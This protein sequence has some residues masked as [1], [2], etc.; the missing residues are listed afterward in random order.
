MFYEA[1]KRLKA[2]PK[3][4]SWGIKDK[5]DN[6][7]MSKTEMLERWAEFYEDNCSDD[8]PDT[9]I[10]GSQEESIPSIL[11]SAI[12]HAIDNL[13]YGKSPGL[14]KIYS[15]YLKAGGDPLVNALRLLFNKILTTNV[16]PQPFK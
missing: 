14:D 4:I 15:E 1:I 10:D 12:T 7:L 16:V 3:N 9:T 11:K 6:I 2:K 5:N 8:S 13:K